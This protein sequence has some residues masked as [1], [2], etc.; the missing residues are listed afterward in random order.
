M[1]KRKRESRGRR[2]G[3]IVAADAMMRGIM[4]SLYHAAT[5]AYP[6]GSRKNRIVLDVLRHLATSELWDEKS[7]REKPKK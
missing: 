4:Q 3:N 6:L 1:K 2:Q 7:R 5:Q